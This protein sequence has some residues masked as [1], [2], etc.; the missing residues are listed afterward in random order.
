MRV[1]ILDNHVGHCRGSGPKLNKVQELNMKQQEIELLDAG[2][3]Y[4]VLHVKVSMSSET[5]KGAGLCKVSYRIPMRY[6]IATKT[7]IK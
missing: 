4:P 3:A 7:S 6:I 1:K 2:A 5:Q